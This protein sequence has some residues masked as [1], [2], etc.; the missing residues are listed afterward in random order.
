MSLPTRFGDLEIEVVVDEVVSGMRSQRF[1]CYREGSICAGPL[2]AASALG[3]PPMTSTARIARGSDPHLA[4]DGH[5]VRCFV[6]P[7]ANTRP[8]PS[9]DSVRAD[10]RAFVFRPGF[11]GLSLLPQ[12][13][14][15]QNPADGSRGPG[16]GTPRRVDPPPPGLPKIPIVLG[17]WRPA[18][19]RAW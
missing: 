14:R 15:A 4:D 13:P 3:S 5:G 12:T 6:D 1:Y 18:S 10:D 9:N 17:P 19:G 16:T 7:E 11:L 8:V 2:G